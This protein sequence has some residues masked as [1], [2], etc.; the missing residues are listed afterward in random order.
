M[1]TNTISLTDSSWCKRRII[2]AQ[3]NRLRM[4]EEIRPVDTKIYREMRKLHSLWFK[5]Q[6]EK[7]EMRA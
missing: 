2:I 3:I 4:F 6:T 7:E 5:G 1:K